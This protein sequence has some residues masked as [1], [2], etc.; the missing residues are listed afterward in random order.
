VKQGL[1]C[2]MVWGKLILSHTMGQFIYT[3]RI[4]QRP[5]SG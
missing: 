5:G 2:P 3:G 4:A 1:F